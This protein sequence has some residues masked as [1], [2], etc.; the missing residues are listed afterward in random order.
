MS[1][2]PALDRRSD[3]G[4]SILMDE[5]ARSEGVLVAFTDRAGGVSRA[6]YASLNLGLRVGDDPAS[7]VTNRERVARAAGFPADRLALTRQVHGAEII[8]VG[9]AAGVIG[10]ADGLVA[11]GPGSVLGILTAD[12]APVAL[13]GDAGI[14]LVHAGWRGVVA[15]VV[16]RGV[17]AVGRV[18]AAWIGPS[19]H[20]CCYDVGLEVVA[21]FEARALPRGPSRRVD[22]ARA[23]ETILRRLGIDSIAVSSDCTHCNPRYFSHRRDG[24][25][26]RQGAFLAL[27]GE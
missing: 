17:E 8:E 20:A 12:C 24:I 21:A 26:G 3:N 27:V 13:A 25:T 6:P 4:V 23:A 1:F 15:G 11:R 19:V 16:E 22:P 18:R 2:S 10:E 14:A 7:V 5:A 9:R